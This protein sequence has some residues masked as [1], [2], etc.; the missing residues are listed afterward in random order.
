M[1]PLS[2]YVITAVIFLAADAVML[3]FVMQ[4]LFRR[5]L[6]DWLVE[7][8]RLAPA[9]PSIWPTSP[10]W[11]GWCPGPPMSPTNRCRP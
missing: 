4:P 2:L 5:H 1:K 7:P 10:G 9:V 6:G 11:S 3:R 8:L